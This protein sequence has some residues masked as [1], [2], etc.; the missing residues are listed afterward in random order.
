MSQSYLLYCTAV[1]EKTQ[2]TVTP[3]HGGAHKPD[4]STHTPRKDSLSNS[5]PSSLSSFKTLPPTSPIWLL[6]IKKGHY[7]ANWV[8]LQLC[9]LD[10]KE[11][12]KDSGLWE[13]ALTGAG[14]LAKESS[15]PLTTFSP[16][17]RPCCSRPEWWLA[18]WGAPAHSVEPL[19]PAPGWS[20]DPPLSGCSN[21][22]CPGKDF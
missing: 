15:S 8:C 12:S 7:Q 18:R 1:L 6:A 10:L 5:S 22:F 19:H 2:T 16:G 13:A 11:E 21:W 4:G 14:L 9:P 17:S 3:S 20:A